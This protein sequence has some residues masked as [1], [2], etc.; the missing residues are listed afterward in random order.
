MIGP[1][2]DDSFCLDRTVHATLFKQACNQ[3]KCTI[4]NFTITIAITQNLAESE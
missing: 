2:A 1:V 3:D 4:M